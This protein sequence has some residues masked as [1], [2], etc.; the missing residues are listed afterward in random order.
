MDRVNHNLNTSRRFYP[1]I[2][3]T[4]A[5]EDRLTRCDAVRAAGLEICSG[6]IVGMGEED[7][8]VVDLA[9]EL[10]GVAGRGRA[11][12]FLSADPRHAAGSCR[13]LDPRDCLKVLGPVSPG[14][15]P[16]RAADRRR[17]RNAPGSLQPLGLYA[18]NSIFVGDYL[19]TKGQPPEEDFQLIRDLGFEIVVEGDDG[20]RIPNVSELIEQARQGDAA[21]PRAAVRALPQLLGLRCAIAGRELAA[22]EGRC[23]GPGAGDDAGGV[24]RLRAI[25]RAAR[26]KN[27]WRWLKRILAHNAADFVRR[28]RGA[29][30]RQVGRESA[31][32]AIRPTA[33]W[34][35]PRAGRPRR[36]AQPGIPADRRRVAG[37]R[38]AGR[39]APPTIK[40]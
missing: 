27:G 16:L 9:M 38:R 2:C 11:D 35:R 18:A 14:Q 13:P 32:F 40:R 22:G 21:V 10:G 30:K 20:Q 37:D 39:A 24:S 8:D 31:P 5:Y 36:H 7:D 33:A 28:Y 4:H 6:G 3:T 17:P 25:S 19:T 26:S 1:R 15:P 23:L 12:Q 34:R 29:A